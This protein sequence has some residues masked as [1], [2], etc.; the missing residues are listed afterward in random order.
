MNKTQ[1]EIN[2][3]QKVWMGGYKTGYSQKR[4]QKGLETYL[5]KNLEGINLLEIGCG[6]GQWSKFIYDL[7][8]FKNIYCIDV[9]SEDHNEFWQY[10]GNEAKDVIKYLQVNDFN[11]DFIED[12]S[13]DFTFSYDVFCHLS[14]SSIET[15]LNSLY[16]KS[17][18]GGKLLIMYADPAKYLKSEPENKYHVIKYLPEKKV[19]YKISNKLLISDALE[20]CDGEPSSPDFEPR[21]YW[22][23]IKNF[24]DLCQSIGFEIINEDLNIEIN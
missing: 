16:K 11:L 12:N 24:I 15:Y 22:I 6:G 13:L 17:K 8:V 2:S 19:L 7:H 3:F 9:L 4:N 5:K 20:D 18:P 10:L 14:Y 1:K 21:W 23:G